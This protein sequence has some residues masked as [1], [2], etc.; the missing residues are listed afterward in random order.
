MK[1]NL[2]LIIGIA[3][4]V[5]FVAII[6]AIV[7]LPTAAVNPGH[8]FLYIT[9]DYGPYKNDY[10]VKDNKIVLEPTNIRDDIYTKFD[11]APKLYL[12]D[13]DKN[14]SYEISVEEAQKYEVEKGPSSPDGYSI[15]R[16]NSHAGIF[17][18]FGS[19]DNNNGYFVVSP[20]GARKNLSGI[21]GGYYYNLQ[22][23]AWIK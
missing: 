2:P 1:N 5:I 13:F 3:L 11:N 12:Y 18:I 9:N 23:I 19:Y 7:Y 21:S 14:S 20:D 10:S 22:V 16:N 8:N 17:E 4:P 15:V 6:A